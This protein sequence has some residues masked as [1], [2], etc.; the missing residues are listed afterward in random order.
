MLINLLNNE[1]NQEE[2]LIVNNACIV[3]KKLPKKIYGF[4]HKYRD[5][6]ITVIN[7]S[8][9][10]RKKEETILHEFAHLELQHTDNNESL[11][12]SIEDAEDEAD[13]YIEFL[14]ENAKND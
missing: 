12:F 2:Y 5:I 7:R 6:N 14:K 10:K 3:Y 13:R 1:T 8:I 11:S 4:I 9:S